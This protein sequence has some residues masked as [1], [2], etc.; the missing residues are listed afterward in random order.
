[1]RSVILAKLDDQYPVKNDEYTEKKLEVFAA[2]TG[3]FGCAKTENAE[4][5]AERINNLNKLS[6]KFFGKTGGCDCKNAA[7][8]IVNGGAYRPR[9]TKAR[10][11]KTKNVKRRSR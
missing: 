5:F 8:S 11:S 3:M 1:L 2:C 4:C 9:A 6:N 10:T 7:N